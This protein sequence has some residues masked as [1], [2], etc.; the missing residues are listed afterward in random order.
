MPRLA[1]TVFGYSGR[2]TTKSTT[3]TVATLALARLANAPSQASIAL[4]GVLSSFSLMVAMAIMVASFRVS[5]D[6]WLLHLLSADMYARSAVA[7]N[8]GGLTPPQQRAIATVPGI[9]RAEYL[10]VTQ[11]SLNPQRPND[12]LLARAMDTP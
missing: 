10:R 9:A 4:G 11:L 7:G 1:A 5:V 3:S 2:V 8:T 6:D 12:A